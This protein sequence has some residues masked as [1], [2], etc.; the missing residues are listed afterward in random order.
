MYR[1]GAAAQV[2]REMEGYKLD[3]LGI[4]ECRWTRT[5]KIKLATGQTVI[6]SGDEEMHEGGVAIMIS[7]QA[8]RSF[9]EWT[10]VNQRIITARF[11]TRYRKVTV[12]QVYAP[13]N[14]RAEEE[15]EQ[16]YQE[17]Q[18]TLDGCNKNDIIIIMGGPERHGW[19][20]QQWI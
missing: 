6:Y 10:P 9:M 19:E 17:L 2:A 5:G 1:G 20:R 8:E 3:I 11:Y 16:F 4:S 15:K 7:Q 13:H 12:I 14:E 18:E